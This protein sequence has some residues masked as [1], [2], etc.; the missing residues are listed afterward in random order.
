MREK[1][2]ML[3]IIPSLIAALLRQ[4]WTAKSIFTLFQGVLTTLLI[5]NYLRGKKKKRLGINA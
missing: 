4:K 2:Y 3:I 5:I 1:L